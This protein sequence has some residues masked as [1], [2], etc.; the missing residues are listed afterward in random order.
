MRTILVTGATGAQGGGVV[1]HL[2]ADG[3]WK[4][5][6]F[7]RNPSSEAAQALAAQDVEVV[8]GDLADRSS[9]ERALQGCDALYGVTNFWEHFDREVEHGRNLADAAAAAGTRD[10][11]MHT[12]PH[13]AGITRGELSV[14]HFDL[15]AQ[16]EAYT[17]ER[18]PHAA[19][20][21]IA[22]YYDNFIGFLPPRRQAD[23]SYAFGFPQGETSLAGVAAEDVG[24]VV[25]GM[26]R[27]LDRFRGNVAWAVGDD[28]P[29]QRYAEIMSEALGERIVYQHVPRETFAA[30]GFPGADDLAQMF[31]FYRR[32]VP[33]RARE[34]AQSR[35]LYPQ[36]QNFATWA[37]RHRE[38]LRAGLQ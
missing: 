4:I 26:L 33:S 12:L 11:I 9:I 35:E 7:T 17:R 3:S 14:P 15:K 5:R 38:Q 18:V 32:F 19:F 30:L 1:R 10:V 20:L 36:I 25:A 22:F 37:P 24:G 13:V 34:I 8:R 29:P 31:D 16:V 21:H 27:D 6:A 28:L 23:G 2:R